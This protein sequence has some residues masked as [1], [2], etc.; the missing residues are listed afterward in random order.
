[1]SAEAWRRLTPSIDTASSL[2]ARAE[3]LLDAVGPST[4]PTVGWSQAQPRALVLGRAAGEPPADLDAC[5]RLGIDVVRRRSGGGPVLWDGNL[6]GLDVWLPRGHPLAP[7]DVVETYRWLGEAL[8]AGLSEIGAAA[9]VVGID[10]AHTGFAASGVADAVAGRACF[11]GLSP[12]EVV[13]DGRKVVGLAQ[14]RRPNGALLQAGIAL[15]VDARLLAE[16]LHREG[17]AADDVAQSLG[18][19]AVGLLDLVP[20]LDARGLVD[21]LE[22]NIADR[23]GAVWS[24]GV[25]AEPERYGWCRLSRHKKDE[26]ASSE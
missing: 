8:A 9:R 25:L 12:Y 14:V 5:A 20:D 19:R 7:D 21:V 13:V 16:L 6:L 22:R 11:G 1:M 17:A 10:E 24:D 4:P 26:T 23:A 15:R 3:A 18:R 2:H